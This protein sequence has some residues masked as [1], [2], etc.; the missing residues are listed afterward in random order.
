MSQ[1]ANQSKQTEKDNNSSFEQIQKQ[2]QALTEG[3]DII[4]SFA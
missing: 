4:S 2:N 1:Q 3:K